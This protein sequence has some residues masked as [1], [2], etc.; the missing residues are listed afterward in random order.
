M[1][2]SASR[3]VVREVAEATGSDPTDLPPLYEVVDPDALDGLF[4][5]RTAESETSGTEVAGSGPVVRFSYADR[6]VSV[7]RDGVTVRE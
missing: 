4:R 3:R 7:R 1:T 5:S 6:H 2:D